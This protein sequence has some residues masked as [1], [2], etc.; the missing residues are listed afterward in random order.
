MIVKKRPKEILNE[1]FKGKSE[2]TKTAVAFSESLLI[3]LPIVCF[4]L[5]LANFYIL[6]PSERLMVNDKI[7]LSSFNDKYLV[8]EFQSVKL[9]LNGIHDIGK[10]HRDD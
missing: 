3:F 6:M 4:S 8:S 7:V 2:R 1:I 9:A 5:L 10:S